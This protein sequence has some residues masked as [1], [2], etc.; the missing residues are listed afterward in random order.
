[1]NER[2]EEVNR[3]EW[4][5]FCLTP[6]ALRIN[7]MLKLVAHLGDIGTIVGPPGIGKTTTL[8]VYAEAH[9]DAHYCVMSPA[10]AS[11]SAVLGLICGAFGI[12]PAHGR[13]STHELI[14]NWV[15][16]RGN[17]LLIVDEAQH[18]NDR[19]LDELRCLHDES[20][21]ALVFTG[22]QTLNS[23][24]NNTVE[25]SFAQ[26]TSRIGPRLELRGS[27]PGDI[28]ALARHEGIADDETLDWL[29][30]RS[31]RNLGLRRIADLIT[32]ARADAGQRAINL[33]HLKHAATMLGDSK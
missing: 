12:W 2:M 28:V 25:A 32:L 26:F 19:N 4:G 23:R 9:E 31:T 10:R 6:T 8:K 3:G 29:K 5:A 33:R 27:D 15:E 7:Q 21:L 13:A 17:Q 1:M 11:M 30:S 24:F 22:N 14:V 16:S 18:L 20:G